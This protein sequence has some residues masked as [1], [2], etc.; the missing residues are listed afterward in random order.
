[1]TFI[2]K[3]I[4]TLEKNVYELINHNQL[5]CILY[6]FLYLLKTVYAATS[7]QNPETLL[8]RNAY[9][10]G[11]DFLVN[12]VASFGSQCSH[13]SLF[14]DV[15]IFE[16]SVELF[17]NVFLIFDDLYCV[18]NQFFFS[19]A[20]SRSLKFFFCFIQ[21]LIFFCA[22]VYRYP[23][24]KSV[25]RFSKKGSKWSPLGVKQKKR[26]C[27]G[28]GRL[29]HQGTRVYMNFFFLFLPRRSSDRSIFSI[30]ITLI[31]VNRA[32]TYYNKKKTEG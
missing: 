15:K 27:M 20:Y 6:S 8:F 25:N 30:R 10:L 32:T 5:T 4:G 14:E 3:N 24:P 12:S 2:F 9:C 16:I 17:I 31:F 22:P 23:T 7:F 11:A 19:K 18:I 21:I 28:Y 13:P 26:E 1:M 29:P